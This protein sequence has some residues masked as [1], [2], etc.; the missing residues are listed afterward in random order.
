MMSTK[1]SDIGSD[2][3]DELLVRVVKLS[4]WIYDS[5]SDDDSN[6]T[7]VDSTWREISVVLS[8]TGV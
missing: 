6:K 7:K 1:N 3:F 2:Y 4:P 5:S 8:S